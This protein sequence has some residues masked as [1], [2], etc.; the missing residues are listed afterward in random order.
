MSAMSD[1]DEEINQAI[2]AAAGRL[3]PEQ[4]AD[5]LVVTTDGEVVRKGD[6]FSWERIDFNA[7]IRRA[8]GR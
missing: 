2:R 6:L 7:M 8:A 4:D 5:V 3:S 1:R